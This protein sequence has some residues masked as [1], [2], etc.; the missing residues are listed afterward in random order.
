MKI[1]NIFI[2]IIIV[3]VMYLSI[4][5][6]VWNMYWITESG[7]FYNMMRLGSF[8]LFFPIYDELKD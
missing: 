4:S 5:F 8:I 1:T 3:I 6:I 2:A 7:I